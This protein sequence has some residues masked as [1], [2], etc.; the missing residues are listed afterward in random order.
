MLTSEKLT[1][2]P[3]REKYYTL[4]GIKNLVR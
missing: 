3:D 2:T 1:S 4:F